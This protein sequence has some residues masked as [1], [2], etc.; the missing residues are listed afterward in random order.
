MYGFLNIESPFM[1]ARAPLLTP[2]RVLIVEDEAWIAMEVEEE[3]RNLGC[4]R[5]FLAYHQQQALDAIDNFQPDFAIVDV[6]LTGTGVNYDIADALAERSIPF[7]FSSGH[8]AGDV[9][10]RHRNR[11]FVSKPMQSSELAQAIVFVLGSSN[12]A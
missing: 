6:A 5:T 10:D 7:I 12:L 8:R 2:D 9:P 3:V 4:Q 1:L 11:P